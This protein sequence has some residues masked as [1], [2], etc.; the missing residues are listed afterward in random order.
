MYRGTATQIVCFN[1]QCKEVSVDS[2][3]DRNGKI[4]RQQK[5]REYQQGQETYASVSPFLQ[6]Q[7]QVFRNSKGRTIPHLINYSRQQAMK[8]P[9]KSSFGCSMCSA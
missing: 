2:F 5:Q 9:C 8:C 4:V 3:T 7:G 1:G 6:H